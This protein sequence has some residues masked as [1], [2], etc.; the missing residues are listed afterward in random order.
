MKHVKSVHY[1]S[2]PRK[3]GSRATAKTLGPWIPAFAGMTN[4]LLFSQP[5]M[6]IIKAFA[7]TAI[8]YGSLVSVLVSRGVAETQTPAV[9]VGPPM[10][11]RSRRSPGPR[12][13]LPRL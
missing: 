9:A 6:R 13:P 5:T 12:S 1:P 7:L 10:P 11:A 2:P 8:L 4:N 3:R